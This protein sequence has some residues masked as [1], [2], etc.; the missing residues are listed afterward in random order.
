MESLKAQNLSVD[1]L[2]EQHISTEEFA[3]DS[4]DNLYYSLAKFH[5]IVQENA[6]KVTIV[7]FEFKRK[8]FVNYHAAAIDFPSEQIDYLSY[9]PKPV[10][11]DAKLLKRYFED[12][13]QQE[14]KNALDLF[15]VDWYA[16][17]D[18]LLKKKLQRNPFQMKPNYQLPF[19][20][21]GSIQSDTDFFQDNVQNKMPW[22]IPN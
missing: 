8:R 13:D 20:I 21:P 4:F 9:E 14:K 6:S 22:S 16:T 18:P 1:E 12:L 3:L 15:T 11:N 7:G 10:S 2:L 19:E 5:D 17:K